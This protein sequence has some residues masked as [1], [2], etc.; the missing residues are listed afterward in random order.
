M[1]DKTI[2]AA[3]GAGGDA[4]AEPGRRRALG[5][6][7]GV[8][9]TA[10][11][12]RA[13]AASR[14]P[15]DDR[16]VRILVP[17]TP[18]TTPDSVAR[19]LA[20]HLNRE[21]GLP[22]VVENRAGASGIIGMEA[23][24]KAPPDG[25]T[26][27]SNVSTTLTLPYF[28]DKLPFDV[29]ADFTPIGLVGSGNFAL[30]VHQGLPVAD[31]AQL[32][33]YA[34]ARPGQLRYASPGLGTHHHLCMELLMAKTGI[35]LQHIPYKGS[36]GATT[37]VL[38]GQVEVMFLPVQVAMNHAASGR[39]K[40]LGG[41]RLQRQPPYMDLP[42]LDERGVAGYD[43]DPWYALWGPQGMAA[44]VVQRYNA[45]LQTL[46]SRA[47]VKQELAAVGLATRPSPPAELT[48][49]AQAE[50]QLWA[51]LLKG[52]PNLAKAG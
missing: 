18:G 40:V 52:K 32:L 20:P 15:L 31:V 39:I 19:I 36:A 48:R 34:K 27:L 51:G 33:A 46:L 3:H 47:D 2:G 17:Q 5:W 7:L 12:G 42:T 11:L 29:L 14:G 25:H 23:A 41:T 13:G 49:I 10:W 37:D 26:L 50:Q 22:F 16:P 4:P 45:L 6:A 24:A 38:S 9:G 30:V 35:Q 1:E 28:Y 21:L 43:V 44:P 8:A